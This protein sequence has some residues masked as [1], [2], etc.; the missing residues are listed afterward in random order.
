MGQGLFPTPNQGPG[1]PLIPSIPGV[2]AKSDHKPESCP[3]DTHSGV[4]QGL[5][6]GLGSLGEACLQDTAQARSRA[7]GTQRGLRSNQG[8]VRASEDRRAESLSVWI[9]QRL[10][11]PVALILPAHR[12]QVGGGPGP[13]P[14]R[15]KSPCQRPRPGQAT[16]RSRSPSKNNRL[17][18]RLNSASLSF[19]PGAHLSFP[20]PRGR[21]PTCCVFSR[22]GSETQM[23]SCRGP[24]PKAPP[25][26]PVGLAVI[27]K[28]L[29]RPNTACP[30]KQVFHL[31]IPADLA[32]HAQGER[33]PRSP[34][35]SA[36]S[37]S[38]VPVCG[39]LCCPPT[40]RS[41]RGL[42]EAPASS[43]LRLCSVLNSE[44]RPLWLPPRAVF[45]QKL[46]HLEVCRVVWGH[47]L[48]VQ[49]VKNLPAM[50]ETWV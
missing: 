17:T 1:G 23:R 50:W 36:H 44:S 5:G 31:P 38:P 33:P 12:L 41:P 28:F 42:C 34:M 14:P 25:A 35:K 8:G 29:R 46:T 22:L 49:M 24:T 48:V 11:V 20:V 13:A 30:R 15:R 47:S 43:F 19:H 2:P 16:V 18:F 37:C 21:C 10:G 45:R 6:E 3:K 32:P 40:P 9:S 4:L 7:W 39:L 27:H 26:P